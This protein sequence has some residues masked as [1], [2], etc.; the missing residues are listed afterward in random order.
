MPSESRNGPRFLIYSH[1]TFGLGHFRR[2][3]KIA[4]KLTSHSTSASVL[5]LTGS[6][7]AHR[8]E[9]P[10]R[11]D[12]VKLPSVVKTGVDL[13]SA[14]NVDMD[15]KDL[16]ALRSALIEAAVKQFAPDLFLVDHVPLGLQG[17]IQ[18]VLAQLR[19]S[20]GV[21]TAVG[22]RDIIDEPEW[23]ISRWRASG[24]MDALT[25]YYDMVVVYGQPEVYDTVREYQLPA[26]VT[27][28][29]YLAG[30]SVED[31]GHPDCAPLGRPR[32]LV[33]VG[34]GEDGQEVVKTYLEMLR[35]HPAVVGFD[36]VLLPGPLLPAGE[37]DRI[38]RE[39]SGLSVEVQPFADDVPALMRMSDLVISMGGY[40]A[41]AEILGSASRA[42]LIPREYPRREQL[43]RAQRLAQLG[44][45]RVITQGELTSSRLLAEITSSLAQPESPLANMR[46]QGRI[47]IDGA[48]RMATLLL[49][50]VAHRKTKEVAS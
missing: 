13:Y 15:I 25:R 5:L 12:F 27:Y 46:R 2:C 45:V 29:G 14:R 37:C 50:A 9:L 43:I 34:G 1:D 26:D 11:V 23:V 16:I 22:L 40:N 6:P 31:T 47:R 39:S 17:E 41:V 38:T 35:S 44:A 42:I 4:R 30:A 10:P 24:V 36:T 32:V 18:N 48:A 49:E 19:T 33:T 8:F 21:L 28:V 3:L 7:L 20:G